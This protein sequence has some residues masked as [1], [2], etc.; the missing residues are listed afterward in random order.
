MLAQ[1]DAEPVADPPGQP[2]RVPG[3]DQLQGV[4]G[5]G[6]QE[7]QPAD[8]GEVGGRLAVERAST[9][10]PISSGPAR[11]RSMATSSS[12]TSAARGLRSGRRYA[13][14]SR[15]SAGGSDTFTG[16]SRYGSVSRL[17]Q[18][19]RTPPGSGSPSRSRFGQD[20]RTMR[21]VSDDISALRKR[22][23][24]GRRVP[25]DRRAARPTPQLET[26]ASRPD[27]WDD[28]DQARLVTGELSAVTDDLE[29]YDELRRTHRRRRDPGRAGPGRSTTTRSPAE[30][31]AALASLAADFGALEL[32]SLFTGEH[33]ELDVD[34]RDPGRR[35]RRRLAGLGQHA[36]AHVPALGRAQG[37]RHRDRERVGGFRSRHLVGLVPGQ[38][39][40][41]LR[42]AA[43]R[44]RRAP[45]RAHEPVQRPGQA[46]DRVRRA[47]G[48]AVPGGR[49]RHR[50]RGQGPAGRHLPLVGRRRPARQ[51]DRL[52]G[53][54]HP[55]PHGRGDHLP[56][57]AQPA[58]E[59][60]QGDA[61]PQG[62][63]GRAAAPGTPGRARRHPW[64]PALGGL[65]LPDPVLR[66]AAVPDGQG[67]AH[68]ARDRQRRRRPRRR[69]RR[70]HGGLPPLA[71]HAS[72]STPD[73]LRLPIGSRRVPQ[74][75][76]DPCGN[77][78]GC[79]AVGRRG[80]KHTTDPGV[81][82]E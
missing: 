31:E 13:A 30:I 24:R 57:P 65:R 75:A 42:P 26:E 16:L 59:Q 25:Q 80:S 79:S 71:A 78:D 61:V 82:T 64:R 44:A 33:D 8:G 11:G 38:G 34:R 5:E 70:V 52:R 49:P 55:H 43:L 18:R 39:P 69:P 36:A 53:A 1:V 74:D 23:T 6:D 58:P 47:E 20:Q 48:D 40:L 2:H 22:H 72:R 17:T 73:A 15:V 14:S 54:P 62:Q 60:G 3:H 68:R 50:D 66:D 28:A 81:P 45:P 4:A 46:P 51:R 63:A 7:E 37:P 21:D 19:I 35:G 41:R 77:V 67:P 29:R 10:P 56:E 32:R 9:N 27:L 76:S 12:A